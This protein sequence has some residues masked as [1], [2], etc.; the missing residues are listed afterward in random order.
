MSTESAPRSHKTVIKMTEQ[1]IRATVPPTKRRISLLGIPFDEY[2]SHLK[3]AASAPDEIW[4]MM[5]CD[6]ANQC[7]ELGTDLNQ[8]PQISHRANLTWQNKDEAFREIEQGVT[9][10]MSEGSKP[11]IFGGDHSITYPI[12][13]AVHPFHN[14]LTILHFDAHPDLYDELDGNRL[15]HA[16][17]FARIMEDELADHLIQIGIRTLNQHQRGSSRTI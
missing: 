16:C 4:E 5:K 1:R 12:L 9:T 10:I 2:S 6:S 14:E 15:S 13:K 17:P 8:H 11:L 7:T 3:G